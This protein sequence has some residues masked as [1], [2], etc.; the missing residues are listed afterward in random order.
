MT[1]VLGINTKVKLNQGV[2]MP[3]F[4][5]GTYQSSSKE[6]KQAVL[7]ALELGYRLIDTASMYG[8]EKEVGEAV[9]ECGIPREEIFVTTK[10]WNSDHGY[11]SA[12]RAFEKSMKN[13]GL[14]YLDLYLIHWP[15]EGLR[16]DSWRALEKLL[17][18]GKCRVVGVSNYMIWHLKEL[19]KNSTTV[20]AVNQ[21]EFSPYLYLKNLLDFCDSHKIKLESYSPLTKGHKLNDPGLKLLASRYSK[22]SAQ[23]LIRWALQKGVVVIPKSSKKERIKENA[24]VFDFSITPEDMKVLDSFNQNLHTSWDPTDVP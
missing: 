14:E 10:L 19:L 2:E 21:I 4:G 13:L 18:D 20:P 17:R 7:Y 24:E 22:T 16:N 5:L 15:V 6:V 8:N 1:E 9:R 12:L 11:E 23:I 3:V